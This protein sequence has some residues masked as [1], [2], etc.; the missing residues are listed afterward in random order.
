MRYVTP[1]STT[2]LVSVPP[3][4]TEWAEPAG[5]WAA[6]TLLPIQATE[7]LRQSGSV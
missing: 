5:C 2:E 1:K 3:L 4:L 7:Y 6:Q